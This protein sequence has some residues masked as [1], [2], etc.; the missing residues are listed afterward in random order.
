MEWM[1]I[2]LVE[3]R[4]FEKPDCRHYRIIFTRCVH[5]YRKPDQCVVSL[6]LFLAEIS[7]EDPPCRRKRN[8][9]ALEQLL[10]EIGAQD[11][12][13][14]KWKYSSMRSSLT[15][16]RI[17]RSF[18]ELGIGWLRRLGNTSKMEMV[19]LIPGTN[20]E[21]RAQKQRLGNPRRSSPRRQKQQRRRRRS[22]R[23]IGIRSIGHLV[24]KTIYIYIYLY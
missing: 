16:F 9:K 8:L 24:K 21:A 18:W 23:R 14:R 22:P 6:D 12:L 3:S 19:P 13:C 1:L 11:K 10:L 17:H 15:A 7:E 2:E 5:R 4:N 20:A